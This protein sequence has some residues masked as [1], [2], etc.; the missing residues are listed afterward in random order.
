MWWQFALQ[1]VAGDQKYS[2]IT[3]V[4]ESGLHAGEEFVTRPGCG[5]EDIIYMDMRKF[6][7]KGGCGLHEIG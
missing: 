7:K 1:I 6:V 4:R 5:R 3:D 2:R